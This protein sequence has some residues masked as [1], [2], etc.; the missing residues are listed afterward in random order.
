MFYNHLRFSR[1]LEVKVQ[2][3]VLTLGE[4]EFLVGCFND[5]VPQLAVLTG[6]G[7]KFCEVSNGVIWACPGKVG[8]I[9]DIVYK[10]KLKDG[11]RDGSVWGVIL[12]RAVSFGGVDVIESAGEN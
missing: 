4:F 11:C 12:S 1:G 9:V 7:E 6:L 2:H 10:P 8:T 3:M 5:I